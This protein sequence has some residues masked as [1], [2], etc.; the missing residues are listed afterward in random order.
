MKRIYFLSILL[1][2]FCTISKGQ[3]RFEVGGQ[4]GG[5]FYLGDGNPSYPFMELN[6]QYGG[7]FRVLISPRYALKFN[8][9]YGTIN[10]STTLS[11][12]VLPFQQ[13]YAFSKKFWDIGMN[14]E[15]NF[16]PLS[17]A[18]GETNYKFTPFIFT[19]FGMTMLFG[20]SN[21]LVNT[22]NIPFGGGVKWKVFE[23]L[24]LGAEIGMRKMFIDDMD[25]Y[26][27]SVD[28][29]NNPYDL[30]GSILI[31]NDYYTCIGVFAA[32]SIFKRK[33]HCGSMGYY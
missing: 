26:N 7:L 10:G 16:L 17:T 9:Y 5:N 30:N 23:F 29:L 19:G 14:F 1:L 3:Y 22:P 15:Y 2:S 31:N 12:N 33:W 25:V 6:Q 4:Y 27:S 13:Q 11:S 18:K 24:T 8:A 21:G 28:V 20:G 32:F